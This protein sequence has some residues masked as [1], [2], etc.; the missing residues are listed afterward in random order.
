M[1]R[2][3]WQGQWVLCCVFLLCSSMA[4]AFTPE[5][6]NQ[7][8][9]PTWSAETD[10]NA[11]MSSPQTQAS[12]APL[13]TWWYFGQVMGSLGLVIAGIF[14]FSKWVLPFW[15][16]SAM[17]PKGAERLLKVCD[18]LQIGPRHQIFLVEI[19]RERR[20]LIGL[21]E[22]KISYLSSWPVGERAFASMLVH[23]EPPQENMI[24]DKD[25]VL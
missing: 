13:L 15:G 24:E 25:G 5:E 12:P 14:A 10:S 7:T 2:F 22:N 9:P 16:Y 6:L 18:R 8:E 1:M 21:S 19:L 20:V 23:P 3:A 17:P 4:K 11:L